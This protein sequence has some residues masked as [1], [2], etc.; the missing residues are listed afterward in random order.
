[1]VRNISER[2]TP[3]LNWVMK[4][5][6]RLQSHQLM[7][8]YLLS[9]FCVCYCCSKWC[10]LLSTH[11]FMLVNE[12][13]F[14][15]VGYVQAIRKELFSVTPECQL[16]L[17]QRD[18]K[19]R[20][21]LLWGVSSKKEW[22]NQKQLINTEKGRKERLLVLSTFWRTKTLKSQERF[23]AAKRKS[24]IHEH[25]KGNKPQATTALKDKDEDALF[26]I[27]EFR[28]SNPVSL[29]RTVWWPLSLHFGIP[30]E[31]WESKA[32]L[33]WCAAPAR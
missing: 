4:L 31:R 29:Q 5:S 10:Y 17:W 15:F 8:S 2:H 22:T 28:D 24:L 11:M 20:F 16:Q 30:G 3:N 32:L 12:V 23:L 18:T 33:G 1:M 7:A 27:G 21:L 9:L 26:E 6:E 13:L 19:Q 14:V 25:G